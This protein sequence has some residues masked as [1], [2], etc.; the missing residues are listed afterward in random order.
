MKPLDQLSQS[1]YNY[2]VKSLYKQYIKAQKVHEKELDNVSYESMMSYWF[3]YKQVK[4]YKSYY[5][6]LRKKKG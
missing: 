5:N 1:G 2:R 4:D 3:D 6:K